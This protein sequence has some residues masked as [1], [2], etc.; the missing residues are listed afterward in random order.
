MIGYRHTVC[1]ECDF[2]GELEAQ[3]FGLTW[4]FC[5]NL[6]ASDECKADQAAFTLGGQDFWAEWH[7][8]G[9]R[10]DQGKVRAGFRGRTPFSNDAYEF[11]H[12]QTYV[13]RGSC[14]A[15]QQVD[16][17]S[18]LKQD[19][20][21]GR[22]PH[23]RVCFHASDRSVDEANTVLADDSRHGW[24]SC[25][26]SGYT[27]EAHYDFGTAASMNLCGSAEDDRG[28]SRALARNFV[29][30]VAHTQ[31]NDVS[32][33]SSS[34]QSQANP[35]G[36]QDSFFPEIHNDALTRTGAA[37]VTLELN[38]LVRDERKYSVGVSHDMLAIVCK[39]HQL[40]ELCRQLSVLHQMPLETRESVQACMLAEWSYDRLTAVHCYTDGSF[41]SASGTGAWAIACFGE[42]LQGWC[43]LGWLAACCNDDGRSG[44]GGS[45]SAFVPEVMALLHALTVGLSVDCD[46][47]VHY[48]CMSAADTAQVH[49][50]TESIVARA[51]ASVVHMLR[52]KGRQVTF[53][54]EKAH[55]G[56]P[57]NELVDRLAKRALT[58]GGCPPEED[59]VEAALRDGL[60][61]WMW[62]ALPELQRDCRFPYVDPWAGV[63]RAGIP[64]VEKE[65]SP[66]HQGQMPPLFKPHPPTPREEPVRK[67]MLLNLLTYNVLSLKELANRVAVSKMMR[68]NN[69]CVAGF[70]ETRGA[71][72]EVVDE[73]DFR[74][75][76][77][78]GIKGCFGCEIWLNK[79]CGLSVNSFAVRKCTPRLLCVLGKIGRV[80]VALISGHVPHSKHTDQVDIWWS[81]FR[82]LL[83][84]LSADTSPIVFVDANAR[85]ELDAHD[86]R[87]PVNKSAQQQVQCEQDYGLVSSKHKDYW[88]KD[89]VTWWGPTHKPDVLDYVM[90]PAAWDAS[91]RTLGKPRDAV[92]M[93]AGWDH[94]PL[95]VD[96]WLQV[97][98]DARQTRPALD[99]KAMR[100]PCNRESLQNVLLSVPDCP[101]YVDVDAQVERIHHHLVD[102]LHKVFPLRRSRPKQAHISDE[103]WQLIRARHAARKTL[104]YMQAGVSQELRAWV[105]EL[106]KG[107]VKR[108]CK[109]CRPHWTHRRRINA[110]KV[111]IQLQGLAKRI[112]V[113]VCQDRAKHVQAAFVAAW[114]QGPAQ[115]AYMI[116]GIV[117]QGRKF[118]APRLAPLL[119][120]DDGTWEADSAVTLHMLS[121]HFAGAEHAVE[122][123]EC[124]V[125]E[126]LRA[127]PVCG[128][129]VV[130]DLQ[131]LPSLIDVAEGF[132]SMSL[133]KASGL[134]GVPAE[135]LAGAPT[136]AAML[137][138][139]V[140][141]KTAVRGVA[142]KAW[143]KVWAIPLAKPG[144]QPGTVGAWRS[145]ALQEAGM[146]GLARA[147]RCKLMEHMV[148]KFQHGQGGSH[149]GS[150]LDFPVALTKSHARVLRQRGQCGAIVF[151]DGVSAFYA[152]VRQHLFDAELNLNDQER[153]VALIEMLSPHDHVR[154]E[155][156]AVLMGPSVFE[157]AS[158]PHVLRRLVA[159]TLQSTF[160][161]M[162]PESD[163]V[164]ATST[165]TTPGAPLADALFQCVFARCIKEIEGKINVTATSFMDAG[166]QKQPPVAT[167]MDD[168]AILASVSHPASLIGVAQSIVHDAQA[169]M[170]KIGIQTNFDQS[171]TEALLMFNGKYSKQYAKQWLTASQPHFIT[172]LHGGQSVRVVITPTY[173][174]L[175]SI[176]QSNGGDDED[177]ARRRLLTRLAY[178]PIHKR[179]LYNPHLSAKEK[180]NVVSSMVERRYLQGAGHWA[181]R[182]EAEL[183]GYIAGYMLFWRRSC[184]P[185][186]GV[187]SI[188]ATDERV[189]CML[190]VLCPLERL[191]VERVRCL[192]RALKCDGGY[193]AAVLGEDTWWTPRVKD[194]LVKILTM[195]ASRA[196][197]SSFSGG[198]LTTEFVHY[199]RANVAYI[200]NSLS[201]FQS[202]ILQ[203]RS[204]EQEACLALSQLRMR[205]ETDNVAVCVGRVTQCVEGYVCVTCGRTFATGAARGSHQQ[206]VH[207]QAPSVATLVKGSSCAVCSVEFFSTDRLRRHVRRSLCCRDAYHAAD[208]DHDGPVIASRC[209][210]W[211]PATKCQG[212]IPFWATLRPRQQEGQNNVAVGFLSSAFLCNLL[213]ACPAKF[214]S[215]AVAGFVEKVSRAISSVEDTYEGI[216]S[217]IETLPCGTY[218][219]LALQDVVQ[220]LG[221]RNTRS[222]GGRGACW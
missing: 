29:T 196:L 137:F 151:L 24:R 59:G 15:P 169:A 68:D 132:R 112:R 62:L 99:R 161:T 3:R 35:G 21:Y 73:P 20:A 10:F 119:K 38:D 127:V 124:E 63:V 27:G 1:D 94:E 85:Y 83:D 33:C 182:T 209:F 213:Q 122:M 45:S 173:N 5:C 37:P 215:R 111:A 165:G 190:G 125:E 47:Q 150:S 187:S 143:R 117:K 14:K 205:A 139:P 194:D 34:F 100:E 192:L 95:Q 217:L 166:H 167:W 204:R 19:G 79:Q 203:S 78:A 130:E 17:P 77:A 168:A 163:A 104:R 51:A 98:C 105:F 91:M 116:R 156:F 136:E 214:E 23:H 140:L 118:K 171:K 193:L 72:D 64:A 88:G 42:T 65:G 174:H 164:W 52:L 81:D 28:K 109:A 55:S 138:Y 75:F 146:K 189:C 216:C 180:K 84:G 148:P 185:L 179:L 145:I 74:R 16:G 32:M 160:F 102:K 57:L 134:S 108:S 82:S 128:G 49:A 172:E 56:V 71:I 186:L 177:I 114:S 36:S 101:W 123:L 153:I 46:M 202:V 149:K 8:A 199:V 218:G 106:W 208:L 133:G 154:Q 211:Q 135:A 110:T 97:E 50:Y 6:L 157:E 54:H 170:E 26:S 188:G 41:D 80:K 107:V 39:G 147:I 93:F 31:V 53:H 142:P 175:G 220:A 201:K 9:E 69:I 86:N 48:D 176:V 66:Q 195:N 197:L 13:Q 191:A 131:H 96:V 2:K 144:K 126:G 158:V 181:L 40:H 115:M 206:K 222:A 141:L 70:Q 152:A 221:L 44:R 18:C 162:N 129:L 92:D 121:K 11:S 87:R 76:C 67:G 7:G 207:R 22:K 200:K 120:L 60:F 30:S 12:L 178:Q 184:R 61:P 198:A 90:V 183:R 212:P 25:I 89:V 4:E 219:V 43:W 210:A 58:D 155:I 103:T 159:T 113:S